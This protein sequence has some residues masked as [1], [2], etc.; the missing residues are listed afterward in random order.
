MTNALRHLWRE[1]RF[2]LCKLNVAQFSAPWKP[3][4]PRCG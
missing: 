3:H 2:S 4:R 1:I